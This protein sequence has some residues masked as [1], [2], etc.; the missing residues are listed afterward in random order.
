MLKKRKQYSPVE[1][2]AIIRR[3]LIEGVTVSDLCDEYGLQPTVFYRWQKQF[4]ESGAKVF[5]G[6]NKRRDN[7]R[8]KKITWLEEKLRKKDEVLSELMEEYVALKKRL[9]LL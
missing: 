8:Q 1:K 2:V 5:E 7:S 4:F 3:H 9:G 6:S